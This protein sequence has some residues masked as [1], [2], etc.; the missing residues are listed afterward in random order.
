MKINNRLFM[1]NGS[2]KVSMQIF[3]LKGS[4]IEYIDKCSINLYAITHISLAVLHPK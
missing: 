4:T 1:Y 2:L 3:S